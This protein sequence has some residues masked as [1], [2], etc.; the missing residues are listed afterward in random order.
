MSAACV[1]LVCVVGAVRCLV[2]VCEVVTCRLLTTQIRWI[3]ALIHFLNLL[4]VLAYMFV[5]FQ[6]F[7]I[8][9]F[10]DT[11]CNPGDV[12]AFVKCVASAGLFRAWCR[13]SL[14][15]ALLV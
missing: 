12:K 11:T 9:S 13:W 5:I 15:G 10:K 4:G 6:S 1:P 14:F 8:P 3:H 7:C 2:V